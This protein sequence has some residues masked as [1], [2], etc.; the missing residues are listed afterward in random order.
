[1][2]TTT[3]SNDALADTAAQTLPQLLRAG[4]RR[5]PD[6]V[7]LRHK[8]LG[9]W[10]TTTWAAYLEQ[11][12]AFCLGLRD[13][14]VS[15]GDRVAIQ[16]E[17]RPEWV[18]ADLAAEALGAIAVGIYP[19]NPGPEVAH[20]LADSG[21]RALVAED[22]EQVDK[23]L[24]VLDDCP[25]LAHVVVIDPKGLH[26]YDHPALVTYADVEQ[27]GRTLAAAE[28]D[29]F[30]ALVDATTAEAVSCIVY[31]SGTTGAP[32]GAMLTH[33]NCLAGATAFV[34]G[35]GITSRDTAVSYL[36]LCHVAERMWTIYISLLT[37]VTINFAESVD[38][39]QADIFEI[40]PTFFGAVPRI[41]EKMQAAV[42]IR[43]AD[44]TWV[45]RKNYQLW[46]HIGRRLARQRL[47]G[48]GTLPLRWWP[49]SVAGNVFLYRPLRERLGLRNVRH[50][51]VGAA[52]PAPELVEWFHAIGVPMV[53]AYGQT[54]CGGASHL[55][56]G[57]DNA[58]DTV[59]T[60]L[61]GYRCKLDP[62]TGEVLLAGDGVF[63]GYWGKPDATAAV[64][65]G[66]WLRTGDQGSVTDRGH[67]K[68]VGRLKDIIVTSGGKNVSPDLIEN[69]LKFSPYV[70]EAIVVGDGRKHLA[71]LVGIEYD[72]VGHWA[73]QRAI[74]YT[75]Y[76]DLSEHPRV[77]E[78]VG[79]WLNEVNRGLAPVE[80]VKRFRLLPKELDHEDAELTATQK[81]RR[82]A[83]AETFAD[84]IEELYR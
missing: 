22:Q 72:I 4:A 69:A 48:R 66:G 77:A 15:P 84:L 47:T 57:G 17:N 79:E 23:A 28:P 11:V 25:D 62:A 51:L 46:L 26:R 7:A 65:A 13:L 60:T 27:R 45:K 71:A 78:L 19:T 73:E 38:T 43:I 61:P 35:M 49:L 59:G 53:Q 5:S 52:P 42:E 70:R 82:T 1:M 10:H 40:A 2:A 56:Q 80:Q 74:P 54:E 30:D 3:S 64:L 33:A 68:I 76:R 39:V 75:T 36:P 50:C 67:L 63:V 31:T 44:S 14:G 12:R 81:V 21:A 24:A 32:K 41:A 37:G 6:Q 34:G 18:F 20:I 16:S 58:Y 55:H 29:A 9:I 83:I 8:A